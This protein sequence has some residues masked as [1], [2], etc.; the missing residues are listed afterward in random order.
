MKIIITLGGVSSRKTS[1]PAQVNTFTTTTEKKAFEEAS[2]LSEQT[3]I[4]SCKKYPYKAENFNLTTY[5][6]FKEDLITS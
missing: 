4:P 6:N 2:H 1:K 3:I 5:K